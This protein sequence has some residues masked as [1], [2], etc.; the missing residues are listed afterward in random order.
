MCLY[1]DSRYE[2]FWLDEAIQT[3]SFLHWTFDRD[4]QRYHCLHDYPHFYLLRN[5]LHAVHAIRDANFSRS[6]TNLRAY[7]GFHFRYIDQSIP[8]WS[9]RILFRQFRRASIQNIV[10][11]NFPLLHIR[12]S[13]YHAEYANRHHGQHI[14]QSHGKQE[15]AFNE[16]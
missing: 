10:L 9:R 8:S 14:W 1:H 15:H 5:W 13:G 12:H 6:S 3:H 11:D 7:G 4:F 2:V 16:N